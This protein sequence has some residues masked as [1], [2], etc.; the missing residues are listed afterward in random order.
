MSKASI[1]LENGSQVTITAN[2]LSQE[3]IYVQSLKINGEAW[4]KNWFD[5]DD[6]FGANGGSIEFEMGNQQTIWETGD[7]PPSPG[8]ID[9]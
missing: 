5:H 4:N 2:N 9:N 1:N 8:H 6:L 7:T 3:N